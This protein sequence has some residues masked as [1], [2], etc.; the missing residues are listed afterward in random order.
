MHDNEYTPAPPPSTTPGLARTS[1]LVT[2]DEKALFPPMAVAAGKGL[3]PVAVPPS[4]KPRPSPRPPPPPPPLVMVVSS[5]LVVGEA[6]AGPCFEPF[7]CLNMGFADGMGG[8]GKGQPPP[9][10]V[11]DCHDYCTFRGEYTLSSITFRVY[12]VL[13]NLAKYP[14]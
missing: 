7:P 10:V 5:F 11:I 2:W 14:A 9:C 1:V 8:G 3:R 4:A 6:C 13:C 12:A